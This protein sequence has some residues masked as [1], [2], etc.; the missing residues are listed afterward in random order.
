MLLYSIFRF[1]M[2][3]TNE[4][5]TPAATFPMLRPL[6]IKASVTTAANHRESLVNTIC[7]AKAIVALRQARVHRHYHS[8]V[9]A[10]PREQRLR[11]LAVARSPVL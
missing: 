5:L 9:S 1:G 11:A 10:L 7:H 6:D 4:V 3:T 2:D 8:L